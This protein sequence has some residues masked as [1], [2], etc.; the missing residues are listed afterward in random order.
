MT[1]GSEL[2]EAQRPPH[3]KEEEQDLASYLIDQLAEVAARATAALDEVLK[4]DGD[5]ERTLL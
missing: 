2:A 1:E 4:A 5:D 3:T